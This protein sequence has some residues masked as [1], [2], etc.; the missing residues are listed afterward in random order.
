MCSIKYLQLSLI[1]FACLF[2]K[3]L[4]KKFQLVK[5]MSKIIKYNFNNFKNGNLIKYV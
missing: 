2:D 5:F 3:E 4:L 1:D